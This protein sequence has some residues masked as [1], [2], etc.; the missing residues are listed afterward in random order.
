MPQFVFLSSMDIRMEGVW[1]RVP[2]DIKCKKICIAVKS[3]KEE[4]QRC[5]R[6]LPLVLTGKGHMTCWTE[7]IQLSFFVQ[8]R[9]REVLHQVHLLLLLRLDKRETRGWS[10]PKPSTSYWWAKNSAAATNW[11]ARNWM[12]GCSYDYKNKKVKCKISLS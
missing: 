3:V 12:R 10:F 9:K 5:W 7:Q 11:W 4:F 2:Y 1:C 6:R 8:R